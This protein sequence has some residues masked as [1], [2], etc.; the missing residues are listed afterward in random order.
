MNIKNSKQSIVQNI[1]MN[2]K[3][4]KQLIVCNCNQGANKGVQPYDIN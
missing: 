2:T 3:N 4:S 1:E